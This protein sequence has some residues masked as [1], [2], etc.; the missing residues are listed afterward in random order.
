MKQKYLDSK[1][2]E[3]KQ[4]Q[5]QNK[6]STNQ[7]NHPHKKLD[8]PPPFMLRKNFILKRQNSD[9]EEDYESEQEEDLKLSAKN[10]SETS[11]P[12]G[13]DKKQLKQALTSE[14]QLESRTRQVVKL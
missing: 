7:R 2:Q 14:E 11:E 1:K 3:Q 13:T 8:R 5:E 9:S 6:T 4:N 10:I 12:N